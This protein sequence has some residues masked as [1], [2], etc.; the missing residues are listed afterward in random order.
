MRDLCP[1]A[2]C[3]ERRSA[4]N[5]TESE[6]DPG[7]LKS[8]PVISAAEAQPPDIDAMRPVGNYGY[9]IAF[10]DGCDSGIFTFDFLRSLSEAD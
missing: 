2:T 1:C 10:R 6:Q 7:A 5:E 3:R 4:G 9:N 8:L